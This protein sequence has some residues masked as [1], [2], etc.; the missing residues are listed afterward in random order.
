MKVHPHEKKIYYKISQKFVL[1]VTLFC[2]SRSD[3]TDIIWI[4]V[5]YDFLHAFFPGDHALEL[6][7]MELFF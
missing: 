3:L 1:S 5:R 6:F 4:F 2:F 7:T